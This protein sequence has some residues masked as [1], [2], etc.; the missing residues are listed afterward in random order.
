MNVLLRDLGDRRSSANEHALPDRRCGLEEALVS[1][2][3]AV[4]A[5][6][7]TGS[8]R[9]RNLQALEGPRQAIGS[10]LP[11]ERPRLDL[12]PDALLE[13]E[14]IAFRPFDQEPPEILESS[15]GSE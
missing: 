3:E 9:G 2:R 15:S 10:A 1:R 13:E 7:Q 14:G 4:N 11:D 6:R 5:G 8:S 12:H